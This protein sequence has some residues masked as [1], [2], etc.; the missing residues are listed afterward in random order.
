MTQILG[1]EVP[2]D[3]VKVM[4]GLIDEPDLGGKDEIVKR[5]DNSTGPF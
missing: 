4:E 1:A 5:I 3:I 2:F